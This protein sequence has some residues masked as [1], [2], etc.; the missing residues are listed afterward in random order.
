MIEIDK[1]KYL[2]L[3]EVSKRYGFSIA[4]FREKRTKKNPPFSTKFNNR[5]KVFYPLDETDRW[6]KENILNY[7]Y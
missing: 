3:K 2:T 4:W 6:F 1:K 7:N 5:G